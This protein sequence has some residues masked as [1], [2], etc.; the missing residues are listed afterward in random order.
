M[1]LRSCQR[2][3]LV[4]CCRTAMVRVGSVRAGDDMV[5]AAGVA[6]AS[7]GHEPRGAAPPPRC[8]DVDDFTIARV[9]TA[10]GWRPTRRRPE[11][12]GLGSST[13]LVS[14][15]EG[16]GELAPR[17]L[18]GIRG[19]DD[20]NFDWHP[21]RESNPHGE[22]RRLAPGV[23]QDGGRWP[24]RQES[25]LGRPTSQNGAWNPPG[26]GEKRTDE[27]AEQR[28]KASPSG[29]EPE[30]PASNT[31]SRIHRVE[32]NMTESWKR[33]VS[34]P[35]PARARTAFKAGLAPSQFLFL[36]ELG[37]EERS[38]SPHP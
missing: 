26:R 4:P 13:G 18:V 15:F 14:S 21:R 24:P 38:R 23:R 20:R 9:A 32:E 31:G 36:F 10:R 37:G 25:N 12:Y 29:I 19:T 6:P 17:V 22:L 1:T 2:S 33:E 5:A 16:C 30:P 27:T 35:T 8:D 11:D 7:R 28:A 3:R 34:N